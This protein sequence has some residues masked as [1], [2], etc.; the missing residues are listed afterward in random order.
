[1][2]GRCG[3]KTALKFA[4][5]KVF[6]HKKPSK[7]ESKK[8]SQFH[9]NA[10]IKQMWLP[11]KGNSVASSNNN[12]CRS[13]AVFFIH[14]SD[15]CEKTFTR[16]QQKTNCAKH[17]LLAWN[18]K[19]QKKHTRGHL[20]HSNLWGYC[21]ANEYLYVMPFVLVLFRSSHEKP[22]YGFTMRLFF[23]FS[24]LKWALII[25]ICIENIARPTL[26]I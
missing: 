22:S 21:L 9:L 10:Y 16:A 20:S 25:A 6:A 15:E 13:H 7:F 18:K 3:H 1:M 17:T 4:I 2:I 14:P 11:I 8:K 19:A 12:K 5:C 23:I 24:A 26:E